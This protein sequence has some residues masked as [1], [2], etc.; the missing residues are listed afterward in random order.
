MKFSQM[1]DKKAVEKQKSKDICLILLPT[2]L[3]IC[4]CAACLAGTTFAWFTATQ[5]TATQSLVAANYDV[6]VTV[7]SNT[8]SATVAPNAN[9]SYELASDTYTVVL[10][11]TGTA[12]TGYCI[13][14][15]G[16]QKFYTVQFPS[17]EN[18]DG[19]VTFTLTVNAPTQMK[20]APQWGTST[21]TSEKWST[22]GIYTLT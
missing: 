11:A 14:S 5:T 17:N 2:V 21:D 7:T 6:D 10:T 18:P 16:E 19:T 12:S 3:G 8:S 4:L 20:I 13:I 22:G 15:F 1:S 9:G